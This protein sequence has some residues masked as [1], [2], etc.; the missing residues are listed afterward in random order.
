MRECG[1]KPLV[2]VA[3]LLAGLLTPTLSASAQTVQDI[4]A[5]DQLIVGQETLLNLYRC[6]F[7]VDTELV[8]GGCIEGW[9]AQPPAQPEPFTRTPTAE[10]IRVRDEGIAAR[11]NLLNAYRCLFSVDIHLVTNG[12]PDPEGDD[13]ATGDDPDPDEEPTGDDPEP[14][15]EPTGDDPDPDEEPTGDD[16]D[17]DEETEPEAPAA[18]VVRRSGSSLNT[19]WTE[20]ADN[21]SAITDYDVQ[22]R[23][24]STSAWSDLDHVGTATSAVITGVA[25]DMNYAVRVRAANAI[26]PGPWSNET[27]I[28][29]PSAG[30]DRTPPLPFCATVAGPTLKIYFDRAI[31]PG[32]IP[33]TAFT[34]TADSVS[35]TPTS[36]TISTVATR[37]ELSASLTL[38]L[39]TAIGFGQDVSVTYT[40]LGVGQPALAGQSG[41]R[42]AAFTQMVENNTSEFTAPAFDDGDNITLSIN[43]NTSGNAVVGAVA[44][45]DLGGGMLTYWLA[46]NAEDPFSIDGQGVIRVKPGVVL[47]YE[48]TPSYLI[49]AH[50]SDGDDA[51]GN[52]EAAATSDD[53]ISVTINV[54]DLDEPPGKPAPPNVI[55]TETR[56]S[57]S[58]IEP[59]NTG[60]AIDDYHLQVREQGA[61]AWTDVPHEGTTTTAVVGGLNAD[62]D[63]EVRVRASN[64]EGDGAWS[65]AASAIESATI[66]PNTVA[67]GA[68]HSCGVGADGTITCWG[69]N[70]DGQTNPP[71]G[72]YS[73]VTAGAWHSCGLWTDGTVVCWGWNED[74]QVDAPRGEYTAVAA[75]G[76]HSCGLRI[77]AIIACWG[78]NANGQSD[79]PGGEYA[80]VAAGGSHSCGLWAD[81]TVVCWGNNANGQSD[82]PSGEYTAVAAGWSHSCGLRAD[83]TIA[84]WGNNANGQSDA[85]EGEYT[86][87]AAGARHS[88]GLRA[89]ATIA[90]WGNNESDQATVVS[91]QYI[92]VAAG[93]NHTCGQRADSTFTCWGSEISLV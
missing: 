28:A 74:G 70:E 87:V 10:D 24:I 49:T 51:Q 3:V 75:G 21:G 83:A 22:Y 29:P 37:P 33:V 46:P 20:P 53:S 63:Y 67:A 55:A 93:W 30:I 39:G 6:A 43:E 85:P 31:R 5:R 17:P 71:A 68:L 38:T 23:A 86:A 35:Q 34:V 26:G 19:T 59:S 18:P 58:W 62:T 9:P 84:C 7:A 8:P 42:V 27:V 56:L 57:V 36:S 78:N 88:C 11:E 92:A 14:D 48:T 16:P 44:A 50:V 52:P 73:A 54:G 89:D 1:A 2:A 82:A 41:A 64:D 69:W 4:E 65:D 60:P 45:T 32:F 81:G 15:E 13:G 47:D 91:G 90:C 77:D 25:C 40:R 72:Q 79:A 61:T 12:C 76:S 66:S 80:A